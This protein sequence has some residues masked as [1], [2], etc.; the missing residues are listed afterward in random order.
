MEAGPLSIRA[1]TMT[2]FKNSIDLTLIPEEARFHGRLERDSFESPTMKN[3]EIWG[4][5]VTCYYI[6]QQHLR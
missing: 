2:S 5:E 4:N 1:L 6:Y 3:G